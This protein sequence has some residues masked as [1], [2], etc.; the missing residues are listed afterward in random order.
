M[1]L[2]GS[3]DIRLPRICARLFGRHVTRH[4]SPTCDRDSAPSVLESS[5]QLP[6]ASGTNSHPEARKE[7]I[8]MTHTASGSLLLHKFI[9]VRVSYSSN[10]H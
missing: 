8:K 6:S 3:R 1:K 5:V 4:V 2:G 9:Q 7:Q 10:C